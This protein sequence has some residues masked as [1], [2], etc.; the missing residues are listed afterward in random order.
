MFAQDAVR[1]CRREDAEQT[2]AWLISAGVS[3]A[4]C[5]VSREH[6]WIPLPYGFAA[7]LAL[8]HER[9]SP[10]APTA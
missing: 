2:R 10:E 3:L 5:A 6:A 1:F 4:A 7:D 9:P 8:A